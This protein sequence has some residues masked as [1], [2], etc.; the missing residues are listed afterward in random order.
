MPGRHVLLFDSL[1]A[2]AYRWQRGRLCPERDFPLDDP[3]PT[4]LSQFLGERRGDLF[5]I[6]ADLTDEG[7]HLETLPYVRGHDRR[8][9]IDR[10]LGQYFRATPLRAA[11]SLG[12]NPDGRRDERLLLCA[13]SAH[14]PFE[15]WLRILS[16][17]EARL[18]G[19]FSLAVVVA[20]MADKLF[21]PIDRAL[22]V[23]L[24]RSGLRH[25]FLDSG[26]LRFSRHTPLV[27][28]SADELG[29]V[30][31]AETGRTYNYLVG[32]RMVGGDSPLPILVVAH[33]AHFDAIRAQ[34]PD[35]VTAPVRCIDLTALAQSC[36]LL[37]KPR[38][39]RSLELWLHLLVRHRPRDQ[40]APREDRRFYQLG[41]V[42]LGLRA[43]AV[44]A[45]AVALGI[46]SA[47]VMQAQRSSSRAEELAAGIAIDQQRLQRS[48]AALPTGP[49]GTERLRALAGRARLLTRRSAGPEELLRRLGG[50]LTRVPE[51]ELTHLEWRLANVL[52]ADMANDKS[53]ESAGVDGYAVVQAKAALPPALTGDRQTQ[54]AVIDRFLATAT[55]DGHVHA[56]AI[57]LPLDTDSAQTIR[58]G[59][60]A[61]PASSPHFTFWLV[62]RL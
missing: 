53:L 45:L 60:A 58:G 26:R 11:I 31:A 13:L 42:A 14:A 24:T 62:Q 38:D 35:S 4:E 43:A 48:V 9:L 6:L 61:E 41:R 44:G 20:S 34:L 17:V 2:S 50:A 12:R 30:C 37:A 32:Q 54:T 15:P 3:D 28:N 21:G 25:V 59:E 7:F 22:I 29:R 5:Y 39:S 47:S 33:P 23:C 1:G 56:R 16:Q 19:V 18:V 49:I 51:I 36:K 8:E 10:K 27:S 40:F 52:D 46:A 55:A 57:G